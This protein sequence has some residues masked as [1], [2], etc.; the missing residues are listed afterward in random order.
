MGQADGQVRSRRPAVGTIPTT[1]APAGHITVVGLTAAAA[2]AATTAVHLFH[3]LSRLHF[4]AVAVVDV[5]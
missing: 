2:A 4:N 5:V 1:T 3:L